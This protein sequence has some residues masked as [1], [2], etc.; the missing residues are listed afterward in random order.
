MPA[1]GF[2][3]RNRRALADEGID[4]ARLP[5]GQY[6]TDRFPV[7]HVGDVPAYAHDLADWDLTV[8]GAVE[9]P[10]TLGW[11][12]LSALP[13]VEVTVDLHCVTKWTKLDTTWGGVAL[14]TLFDLAG[15]RPSATHLL[16]HAEGGYST[17]LPLAP[18]MAD[19]AIL[20]TSYEG[21][22]IPPEHGYP[23]RT[24][25]PSLYL[26]KSAKWV[27]R[28]EL[29]EADRPGF[30]EENGYHAVGDPFAEQRFHGD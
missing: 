14:R 1:V 24:V 12:E 27:R 22:P 16:A 5:P 19:G 8:S 9:R 18:A 20:A 28:L 4:P 26:W 11:Q 7:L 25:V 10:L 15:A 29:L 2:F 6:R 21:R 17:N 23:A 3:D 30:W 13:Q